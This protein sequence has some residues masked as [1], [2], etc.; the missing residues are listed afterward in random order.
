MEE[1]NEVTRVETQRWNVCRIVNMT[2]AEAELELLG[3][4]AKCV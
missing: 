1:K 4:K 3:V 2:E